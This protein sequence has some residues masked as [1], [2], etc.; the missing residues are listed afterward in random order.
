[1]DGSDETDI[2]KHLDDGDFSD[3]QLYKRSFNRV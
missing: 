3:N 2:E 1:M